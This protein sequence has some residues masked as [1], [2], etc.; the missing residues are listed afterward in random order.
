MAQVL[1]TMRRPVPFTIEETLAHI[2][3][4]VASFWGVFVAVIAPAWYLDATRWFMLA[5]LAGLV[6]AMIVGVR[7]RSPADAVLVLV[8]LPWL[9]V[10]A[11][12]VLYWTRTIDYGEQGRLAH[13]GASAF[14][15]A[16]AAGWQA[17]VPE[18][19]RTGLHVALAGFMVAMALALTPFLAD[20]FG[21]PPAVAA[22][23]VPDRPFDVRF[24]GG[25]RLV[26]ADFPAGAGLEPGRPLPVT[27]YF[28]ADAPIAG[29]YTLFLHL[30]DSENRLIDPFDGV[31]VAGKHPTRQ[32]VPGQIF[33]DSHEIQ[34]DAL[35]AAGLAA[36][37]LGFYPI[38]D[39]ALRQASYDSAG[40][41]IGDRV[42]LSSVRLHAPALGPATDAPAGAP[43]ATWTNGI[44]LASA[45]LQTDAA[46]L[47]SG[48]DLTWAATANVHEDY[49]VFVQVLDDADRV[50]AQSDRQPQAGLFPTSTWRAGD[51]VDDRV[52]LQ[53][54]VAGWQR[55]I[56]G[57]YGADGQR[58]SLGPEIG[59]DAYL[60]AARER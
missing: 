48:V 10:V 58:L 16:M 60:L 47:P 44:A 35:P 38:D 23:L 45:R 12:S 25:M 13:I 28:T 36:L 40:Q 5:G 26:G 57:L 42:V 55:V 4:L 22:G 18:R 30:A 59:G 17:W 24:A 15:V 46:G 27:L 31:P 39:P 21:L 54:D 56:V 2:P 50:L 41:R 32:W 20:R 34:V 7:R 9:A 49:T 53:G 14:G 11:L 29:D 51:R 8:L 3:W 6:P 19:W 33:A 52:E 1:P 37:S 43:L